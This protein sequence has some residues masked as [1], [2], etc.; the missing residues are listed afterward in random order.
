VNWESVGGLPV[1]LTFFATNITKQKYIAH[2]SGLIPLGAENTP[3]GPP[4]MF[5]GRLKFHF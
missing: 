4:R 2:V 5:G 3:I 1:D